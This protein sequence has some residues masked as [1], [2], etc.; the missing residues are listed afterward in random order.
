MKRR[1]FLRALPIGAVATAIPFGFSKAKARALFNSPFLSALVNESVPTDRALVIIFMEG[2]NDGLNT[3]IPF[4]DPLYDKYRTDIGFTTPD[5]KALLKFRVRDDLAFNPSFNP[6]KELWNEGKM[7]IIQN[8]GIANP[9]LSHFRATDIWNSASD[10][11]LLIP[12]GWAGRYLER[13]YPDYPKILPKDPIAI[14]MGDL[15]P[16]LFR[17]QAGQLDIMVQDPTIYSASGELTDGVFPDTAGGTELRFVKELIDISNSYSERFQ[18]IFPKYA[19]NRV[20][21]PDNPLAEN[22]RKIAWCVA[23]GMQTRIYFTYLN[24]F[25]THTTQFSKDP[26]VDGQGKCLKYV[27]ES[28][29]AFQRDLEALGIADKVLTMTY[30]EFGRRVHEGGG[31]ASGT[32]HGST[33]PHFLFGTNVNGQLYGDHPNIKD[34]DKN[35]DPYNQFE[36]RQLY[37]SV[38]G[39]WFG[40]DESLRTSILSPG[41]A[42][43][44]FRTTF[45]INGTK[46]YQSLIKQ[47]THSVQ[48]EPLH[49]FELLGAFPNPF[50]DSATIR[51][52]LDRREN[53]TIEVFDAV[54][55]HI[56]TLLQTSLG[57][58]VHEVALSARNF[59]AGAYYC[60]VVVGK[61]SRTI[62]LSC[63][64]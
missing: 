51:F 15:Q 42:H 18:T 47:A 24:G 30:S 63:L 38:L 6:L 2:G 62:K 45:P 64:R 60:R 48:A 31:P 9:D 37:A 28:V 54:G 3:L 7:A 52:Q 10:T 4:E 44:P 41:R 59:A 11:D 25:D 14:S 43:D 23:A 57:S 35:G 61:D 13:L 1:D 46:Y 50:V 53:V 33:A 22:L 32:D 39:D 8:L 36:F 34:L 5:E 29:L 49:S 55:K 16:S 26:T 20:A 56:T 12:T 17:G 27:A 40:V 58:G 21:Y 19:V